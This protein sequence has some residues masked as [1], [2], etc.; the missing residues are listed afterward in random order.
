[1][2]DRP[3][4][5]SIDIAQAPEKEKDVNQ[6]LTIGVGGNYA[7]AHQTWETIMVNNLHRKGIVYIRLVLSPEG[8]DDKEYVLS[9]RTPSGVGDW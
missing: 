3:R 8:N 4:G 2:S 6:V 7:K 1:M 9:R 5:Y